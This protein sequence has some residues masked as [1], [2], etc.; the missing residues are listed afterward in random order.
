MA[1]DDGDGIR[2]FKGRFGIGVIRTI[3]GLN[4]I[5]FRYFVASRFALG[6]NIGVGLFTFQED[7]PSSTDVCPG[8]DCTLENRRTVAAIAASL[9]GIYYARLGKPAGRL[10]FRADFGFGGRVGVMAIVNAQDVA[11][12]L[13]DATEVHIELPLIVQLMFGENFAL[14]PEFGLDFRIVPGDREDPGDTNPGTGLG[15]TVSPGDPGVT[16]GPGFGFEITPGIGLFGG[17][18][19]H[20]Y[21]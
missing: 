9:E 2:D 4:G 14:A 5:N 12:N 3:A 21:F 7:D 10:P 19:M 20:Y 11:D 16:N 6:A 15:T 18:S 1:E 17:A 13:D 8:P